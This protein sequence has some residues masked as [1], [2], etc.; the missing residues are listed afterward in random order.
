MISKVIITKY[1][2]NDHYQETVIDKKNNQTI[3]DHMNDH[4]KQTIDN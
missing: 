4:D 3:K 2:L 1:H